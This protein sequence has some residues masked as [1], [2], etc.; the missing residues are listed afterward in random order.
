MPSSPPRHVFL[1]RDST[2]SSGW[3][4]VVVAAPTGVWY[5]QRCGGV[6]ADHRQLEGYLVPLG[7]LKA[8][9]EAGRLDPRELTAVFH[10]G[11][12]CV[13][14]RE[15]DRLP[16]ELLARL[17]SLVAAMP[18]RTR[19]FSKF[20]AFSKKGGTDKRAKL[21]LDRSRLG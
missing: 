6:A 16:A 10:K 7:G 20:R 12:A 11:P 9:P 3:L 4:G 17:R 8:D 2:S 5:H 19:H 13:W 18:F 1:D 14:N 15:E 21:A